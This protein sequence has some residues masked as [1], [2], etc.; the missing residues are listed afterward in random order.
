MAVTYNSTHRNTLLGGSGLDWFWETDVGD[1]T[2][3]K[4]SDLLN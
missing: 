4:A 2:N 3:R 1:H